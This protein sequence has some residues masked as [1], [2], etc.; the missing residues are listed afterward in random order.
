MKK[1]LKIGLFLLVIVSS[2]NNVNFAGEFDYP[3]P[4]SIEVMEV[5]M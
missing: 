1:L 5:Q 2:I 4:C 3:V